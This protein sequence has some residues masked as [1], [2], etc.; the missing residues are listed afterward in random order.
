MPATF[1][2]DACADIILFWDVALTMLNDGTQRHRAR[3]DSDNRRTYPVLP[4]RGEHICV[5]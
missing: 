2:T 1:T 4:N 5:R 3:C